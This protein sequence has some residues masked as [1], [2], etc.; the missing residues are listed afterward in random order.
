[1]AEGLADKSEIQISY[2]IGVVEPISIMVD[3]FKTGKVKYEVILKAINEN[4]DLTLK[5]I[6]EKFD[7]QKSTFKD[8][9][10]YGHFGNNKYSWEQLDLVSAMREYID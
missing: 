3:T 5:G 8:T 10:S 1:M 2:A 9:S 7:L 6:V 4:F